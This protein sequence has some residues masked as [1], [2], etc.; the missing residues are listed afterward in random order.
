VDLRWVVK[1]IARTGVANAAWASGSL[2]AREWASGGGRVRALTYHRFGA[3]RR[4]PFCVTRA[5]LDAQMRWLAERKLLVS[6]P[7]V[8]EFL[9]GRRLL[10]RHAV[11]VTIDD[12]ARSL[13]DEALP[14]LRAYGVPAVAFVCPGLIGNRAAGAQQP[15]PYLDWDELERV[16]AAGIT[17]GSHAFEHRSLGSMSAEEAREQA[18][19]SREV[20]AQRIGEPVRAFAYPFGTRSDF[21]PET[22][23]ILR[24]VGYS[25]AFHSL[26]GSIRPGSP[27]I[28]LPRVKVEGGEGL[29][30]FQL[31]CRGA[32]DAW[33]VVDHLLWRAQLARTETRA[34]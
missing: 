15:E 24:E 21:S 2:A 4:D 13:L 6:L 11:L 34:A 5:D 14:V 9:A 23:R 31:T 19:R 17:I 16:R 32:M 18:Q 26:H 33:R 25:C 20:L 7:E 1:K 10:P 12:G 8:E 29:H 28:S 27:P 22:D 30:M 3:L